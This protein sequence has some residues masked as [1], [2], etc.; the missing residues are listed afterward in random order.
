MTITFFEQLIMI[1][2]FIIFGMFLMILYDILNF[3]IVKWRFKIYINFLIETL[4]WLVMIF[5]ACAFMLRVSKGYIPLYTFIFYLVGVVL[6][7]SLF[8][9]IFLKDLVYFDRVLSKV[10]SIIWRFLKE[11]FFPREVY[12]YLKK[13]IGKLL[14]KIKKFILKITKLFKFNRKNNEVS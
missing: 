3:Y 1:L 7:Q 9:K 2:Y 8:K 5:V 11:I 6:Y 13:I 10:L 12:L 4:F 14:S